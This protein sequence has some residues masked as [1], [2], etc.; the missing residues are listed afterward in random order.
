MDDEKFEE[1]VKQA[2]II[3]ERYIDPNRKWYATRKRIPFAYF[4]TAGV[5]TILFSV[6]LPAVAAIPESSLGNKQVILSAMSV[7]IAALTGLSSF[8]R[9]SAR[10][11]AGRSPKQPST[12]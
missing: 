3:K 7:T 5:I 2:R 4:R 11:A 6:A 12:R 1:L 8:Y 9:W 10:G